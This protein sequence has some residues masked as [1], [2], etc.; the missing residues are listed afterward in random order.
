MRRPNRLARFNMFSNDR[1]QNG[2]FPHVKRYP[3]VR[4]TAQG[5]TREQSYGM[6][7]RIWRVGGDLRT[8]HANDITDNHRATATE[9]TRSESF[10]LPAGRNFRF[11]ALSRGVLPRSDRET[12][13]TALRFTNL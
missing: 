4:P 10:G 2:R 6:S 9:A 12:N 5:A 13:M 3:C 11:S 1:S 7:R 8:V